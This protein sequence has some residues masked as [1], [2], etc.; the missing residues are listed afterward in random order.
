MSENI[1]SK[2]A[3]MLVA[4]DNAIKK[5]GAPALIELRDRLRN[6]VKMALAGEF[7]SGKTTLARMLLG[8]DFVTT[9]AAA[10]A[11][12]TVRFRYGEKDRYILHANGEERDIEG[13]EALTLKDMRAA[14]YLVIETE[15]PILKQIEIYDTPGTSDPTRDSDQI[16]DV[17]NEV[18][19]II[20]CTNA[21]QAWRQSE[22]AM[23]E[24][25]PKKAHDHGVLLVTHVDLPKVK[26]S[27]DRLMKRMNKEAGPLFHKVL[28]VDL[29]TAIKSRFDARLVNNPVGWQE[30]GGAACLDTIMELAAD[31][32]AIQVAEAEALLGGAG[33]TAAAIAEPV[34]ETVPSAAP[35]ITVWERGLG[36][37]KALR[38]SP[39][40]YYE[41]LSQMRQGEYGE[42]QEPAA[43]ATEI[44]ARLQEASDFV[45]SADSTEVA[46]DV[47]AQLDW[48][49]R[50]IVVADMVA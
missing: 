33:E 45:K 8:R 27:I 47:I 3:A 5:D 13:V 38:E 11:M 10:S 29:L 21:T 2:V 16:I 35:F 6:P 7:S 24:G 17:A 40:T 32:R 44:D 30:S 23:W 19:F 15:Q 12:P 26:A 34:I 4:L 9:K 20:W 41:F 46:R 43:V 36:E 39:V 14:D 1:E 18:E 42:W 50:N 49:F 48:E 37:V 22:R 31:V 25:L 28:P